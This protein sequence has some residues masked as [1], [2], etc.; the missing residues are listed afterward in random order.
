MPCHAWISCSKTKWKCH[1][2]IYQWHSYRIGQAL[3]VN[4][5][6]QSL[7]IILC[8]RTIKTFPPLKIL[9][10][11]KSSKLVKIS[12]PNIK[13][14]TNDAQADTARSFLLEKFLVSRPQWSFVALVKSR[15][16]WRHHSRLTTT[17][18]KLLPP[19]APRVFENNELDTCLWTCCSSSSSSSGSCYWKIALYREW[20][21]VFGV[22][23]FH[24]LGE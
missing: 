11:S 8:L 10:P 2:T 7:T 5:C 19:F 14:Q 13:K 16:A 17:A 9:L 21:G 15:S 18:V 3:V 24:V 23:F 20:S 22:F 4:T 12:K 1:P 6:H